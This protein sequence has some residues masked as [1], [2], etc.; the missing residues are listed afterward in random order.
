[1]YSRVRRLLGALVVASTAAV[2]P[3]LSAVAPAAAAPTAVTSAA[4]AA[5]GMT[6]AAPAPTTTGATADTAAGLA[7]VQKYWTADRMRT[8][9][10]ATPPADAAVRSGAN[11]PT[12]KPSAVPPTGGITAA[13]NA[14]ATVGRVFF[15]D[16]TVSRNRSCSASALN[17]VSKQLVITAGHCVHGGAGSR[18]WMQNWVFVPLYNNGA[19]P[20]GTFAAKQFRTFSA[21]INASD[22]NF[23]I[24]MVT[25]WTNG[26]GQRV[27][28]AVGGNGLAWNFPK[29][30]FLTILA[31][32][33]D[34]PFDGTWQQFCQ[35]TT[36]D[37][38]SRI[39]LQ[40]GFTGG[41]S[42]GPW[43]K[44]YNGSLGNVNGVM[45]TLGANGWNA[46]AYFNDNVKGMFDA[47]G[48]V[49]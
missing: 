28:D 5:A 4:G 14:S 27:V 21:W 39:A 41:S 43:L 10:P 35:G 8:A 46:A 44:D 20:F 38:G 33:A 24:A 49:T 32:P 15:F 25:T 26:S 23:D 34:P 17:S 7:A 6:T 40:C 29:V 18:G 16:P 2:V 11:G 31:Y 12:G 9:L 37:W 42:G 1:M 3:I 22:L 19:A 13:V 45:S 47:Q 30:L 48:P 36:S